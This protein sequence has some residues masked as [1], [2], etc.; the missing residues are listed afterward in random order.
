MMIFSCYVLGC[1]DDSIL[2]ANHKMYGRVSACA[3][4]DPIKHG[5][6]KP[7]IA[8]GAIATASTVTPKGGGGSKVLATRPAPIVP[9]SDGEAIAVP[10]Y[11]AF[12]KVTLSPRT[13]IRPVA[14]VHTADDL[15]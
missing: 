15:F 8:P 12:A 10:V 9:P 1:G 14:P 5:Y 2:S 3:S 4:H 7:L 11:P 6:D 13:A